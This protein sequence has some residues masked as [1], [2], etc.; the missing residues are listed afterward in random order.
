MLPMNKPR[1]CSQG[2]TL[3]ELTVVLIIVSLLLGGLLIPLSAQQDV[4]QL[5]DTEKQLA[6]TRDALIGYAQINGRLPCPAADA[7]G[8]ENRDLVSRQCASLFGFLPWV[9]LGTRPTDPWGRLI[10]Y[11]VSNEFAQSGVNGTDPTLTTNSAAQLRIQG[12]NADGSYSDL[13][14]DVP[15]EVV[16]AILSHGK[17]GYHATN[18]DGTAGPSDA[19][20]VNPDEDINNT[21]L[22]NPNPE[23]VAGRATLISRTPTPA[24]TPTLGAFD[25]QLLWVPRSVLINRLVAAGKI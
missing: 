25:D 8:L 10:R 21:A 12:H 7:G 22:S 20:V 11:R 15:R 3:V 5:A 18:L 4:R 9:N 19:G 16:F 14:N 1:V 23:A 24:T 6:E 13:T 2:F 17:N